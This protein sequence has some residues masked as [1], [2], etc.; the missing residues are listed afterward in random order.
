MEIRSRL[1]IL[2]LMHSPLTEEEQEKLDY[3]LGAFGSGVMKAPK[4]SVLYRV[5]LL[6]VAGVMVLLPLVYVGLV[7]ALVWWIIAAAIA[8]PALD[9]VIVL[10]PIVLFFISTK[11]PTLTVSANSVPGR[12]R[13]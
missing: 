11:L 5:G 3:L 10:G 13:A 9:P 1:T 2:P 7:A 6:A 12:S 4:L 8:A